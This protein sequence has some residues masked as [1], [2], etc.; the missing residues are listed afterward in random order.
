MA[1]LTGAAIQRREPLDGS[2]II[3]GSVSVTSAGGHVPAA[4]LG[5]EF[6]DDILA[7]NATTRVDGVQAVANSTTGADTSNGNLWL[8]AVGTDI[9]SF[10]VYGR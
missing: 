4:S 10:T 3:S 5:I 1:A 7:A 9:V 2:W 8:D 6:I